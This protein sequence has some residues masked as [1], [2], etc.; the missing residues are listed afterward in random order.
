M[1]KKLLP[2][3]INRKIWRIKHL[4]VRFIRN[5]F[6]FIWSGENKKKVL[7][8]WDLKC[9]P[10]SIGDFLIFIETL[11]FLKVRHN[12]E[13][14]DICIVVDSK[15]PEGNRNEPTVNENNFRHKLF[16]LLPVIGTS[17]YLGSLFQFDDREEFWDF[18]RRNAGK[19]HVFPPISSQL[20]EAYNFYGDADVSMEHEFFEEYGYVPHLA[21]GEQYVNWAYKF[22][23]EDLEDK[24][25]VVVSLRMHRVLERNVNP[26]DWLGFFDL[27]KDRFPEVAFVVIGS[28]AEVFESLRTRDNVFVAKDY[29]S[30]LSDDFALMRT[31]LLYMG[32]DSGI[33]VVVFY[34]DT[35]YLIF[36]YPPASAERRRVG[37]DGRLPFANEYQRILPNSLGVSPQLLFDEFSKL[38]ASLD[39]QKWRERAEAHFKQAAAQAASNV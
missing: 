36:N 8:I 10:W 7:G 15:A 35:P 27:C 16:A 21:I 17:P 28:R 9:V 4:P 39:K 34:S 11:S 18:L 33:M 32:E 13:K 20:A 38:Y 23:R 6:Q 30:T 29:G 24:L 31:S 2:E 3:H 14:V 25:P 22:Y 26:E 37:S 1:I 19:Y 5:L 12:A